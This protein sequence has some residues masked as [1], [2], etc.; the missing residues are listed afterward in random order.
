MSK[1]AE[2]CRMLSPA[3]KMAAA[4]LKAGCKGAMMWGLFAIFDEAGKRLQES[5]RQ[6]KPLK[7][8]GK[9]H[10]S[11]ACK[12]HQLAGVLRQ[13]MGRL[14]CSLMPAQLASS[15]GLA[16]AQLQRAKK[17]FLTRLME[18]R[19]S[20]PAACIVTVVGRAEPRQLRH[21]R[22]AVRRLVME[23]EIPPSLEE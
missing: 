10:G 6:M 12:V 13:T 1:S 18:R 21:P 19:T 2:K 20:A 3:N 16:I 9:V 4:S 15:S 22:G 14:T 23:L 11:N 17:R 7:R 8:G 5:Q